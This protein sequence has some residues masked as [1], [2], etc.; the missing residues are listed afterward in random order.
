MLTQLTIS[1]F[2]IVRELEIDFRSGMTAITGETGAG[3]SIAI[4]ALGLCL[5]NRGEANMVRAGAP[6]TDLC[7]RFSLADA[8]SARKW[9]EAHQL[10]SHF[11]DDNNECL[12][13]RTIT[14][15]GRSRGFINGT[16]V[17]LSQLRELG[18][19]LIQIH[20]Q[21][22][23]QLLLENRHQRRLLDIYTGDFELQHEMK[24]AYQQWRQSCQALSLFQQQT[25]ERRSRQQ[26][27]EYHL[28]ELNE[29]AP[30]LGE[31]Q[32]QDSEYKR[33]AN[34]GQFL[35]A[36]QNIL[37]VLNDNDEQN[38]ISLLSYARSE[39]TE[40]AG[41]DH[42]LNGLLNMLEEAA[43]QINEVSD[44]LRHYSDQL[45]LDP[46]RLFEL[47]QK[48]SQ[49][50]SMARK[51]HVVPEDLPALHQQLLEE[52]HQL[53]QQED[54]CAH[55]SERV[56]QHY[57]QAL[58][59]AEKLHHIRQ[60]YA[61][62]LGQLITNSMHQ[63]SMPHGRFTLD[64]TF[65]PENL[66]I[67]GAS[68]VEFNVTTNPGQPHQSLAK[69]ASGGELSRIALAIQVIT[70]K[71][72]ETPALIFDEVD[73]GISG[74]TAAIV[75]RLLRELGES[76]QVMCVTHLPQVAGC[77][78]QHF[79]VSKQTDG[80]ETE[81]Q[82]QLLDKKARLQELARLLAGNEVTKNTLAN[83]KEL[84]AA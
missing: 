41:M 68:K 60:K 32:E 34:C 69:V 83:A 72:M 47:E 22:A 63:L 73:V 9:L 18:S 40:L 53:S 58:N 54:D 33:L 78:H 57:Q 75:G 62:E 13:R 7:A 44:E 29:L 6:R 48:I 17:P 43:I 28:K 14:A 80:E 25:L 24:Q 64:I 82:M 77:G 67:D 20:G 55:L 81:T 35:S 59:V 66:S 38:I 26:L 21:H 4:D 11:D 50:I 3:K 8:P 76:T 45:E 2:A 51:H 70:A 10:D 5:G 19:R 23:H 12:L 36:S 65:E 1:N 56:S 16:A 15:D 49:Q 31:Y 30:Q 52:Q 39:L 71:K 79:Y 27:L 84:L 61:M 74:P 37:Q 46:N 42:K